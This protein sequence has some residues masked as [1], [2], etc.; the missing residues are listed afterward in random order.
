M[1]ELLALL[2]TPATIYGLNAYFKARGI[3]PKVRFVEDCHL[4]VRGVQVHHS[5]LGLM[6]AA[7]GLLAGLLWIFAIGLGFFLQHL[8]FEDIPNRS[9]AFFERKPSKSSA[10]L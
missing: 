8:I 3:D 5:V 9:L 6:I 7:A 10:R 2:L 1:S 4:V